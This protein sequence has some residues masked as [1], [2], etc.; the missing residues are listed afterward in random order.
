MI[1]RSFSKRQLLAMTWWN[2]PN[3][4]SYDALICDG[5][6]RSGK[7]VCMVV[8]FFLWSMA[9]FDGK[10]FALCGK[11]IASLRRNVVIHLQQ[12]LGGVVDVVE[13]RSDNRLE[14]RS[15]DGRKNTYFLFGGQD[16]SSYML[17][18]GIT[19]AGALLDEAVLMPRSFVEQTCARCSEDGAKLWFNCNPA[20]P[21]H[22]FYKEWLQKCRE[23]NVLHLHFT[24]QDN[25]ALPPQVRQRYERM[26]TGHFYRRYVLGQWCGAEGLVYDFDPDLHVTRDIPQSGRYYISV[27]YGTQN[28]F[29]AGL[30]C[31]TGDRAVRLRE[32]YYNGREQG[33]MRTDQEYYEA[34]EALAGDLPVEQVVI[35]PSAASF[36]AVV[37]KA[38]RF[39][40]RRANN[41]VLPGI[42]LVAQLLRT[43][44][45]QFS[46]NCKAAI[47]EFSLYSWVS[48]GAQ[49]QPV[50]ENDHA[51]DDI[52][53]FCMTI[54][55][56]I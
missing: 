48:E 44:R 55:R 11:T 36:I 10:V 30:W 28:P 53:Y 24:M 9:Q 20:S 21:E 3:L 49:D 47:R 5:A 6:V 2:R 32:Y 22:W 27:D 16:E 13:H 18:Q 31:V 35:D 37:R 50:K 25:P 51:M 23:K 34:L 41:Q 45:L 8:G 38:G 14:V 7:T 42:Q 19:L 54:L 4:R 46:P 40:I 33:R 17:I 56:R 1:Y 29:S 15:P 12:W 39:R 52:R 43:G 26:Y